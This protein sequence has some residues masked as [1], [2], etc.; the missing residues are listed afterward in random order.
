M[1]FDLSQ[2]RILVVDD[3][4]SHLDILVTTLG[5]DYDVLVAT[6]GDEALE[7]AR[8]DCPD[9]ILLDIVMPGM[10]GYEV[11]HRLKQDE[12]TADIPVVF[13]TV[14][15]ETNHEQRGL[16]LGA[17]DY[18]RKPFSP[19]IVRARVRNHLHMRKAFKE[20]ERQNLQ[21]VEAAAFR[22]QVEQITRHDLKNP[23]TAVIGIPRLLLERGGLT[24]DQ[25]RLLTS[26]EE[27]G[28][29]MFRQISFSLDLFRMESGLYEPYEETVDVLDV[30][31]R[32]ARDQFA[33]C[34]RREC[35]IEFQIDGQPI[36][37]GSGGFLMKADE[38]LL[39]SLFGNL[40]KNACEACPPDSTITLSISPE[41]RTVVVTNQGEVPVAI[42]DRFFEKGVSS[43]KRG[44]HG[45]GTYSARL[46]T[47]LHGGRIEADFTVPG[48][49]S[50]TCRFP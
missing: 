20:L 35:R 14:M 30:A 44:G 28:Q 4:E 41:N 7:I 43:A 49:T 26:L 42:R 12:R 15:T 48:A 25:V 29:Q 40:L 18:I 31:R 47:E 8:T 2:S 10:D 17:V 11:C 23:L 33:L 46:I 9:L 34:A 36:P 37:Q 19:A 13:I 21:L 45:L 5:N 22:E 24:P 50:V 32:G 38:T 39:Y 16:N 1:S 27:T 6:N 3:V